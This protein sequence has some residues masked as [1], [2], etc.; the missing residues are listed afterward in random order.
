M[1]WLTV[2][3]A[4]LFILIQYPLWV[5]TGG[6][7]RVSELESQVAQHTAKNDQLKA[8]NQTLRAEVIDLKT[9]SEAIEERA[10]AELSMIKNDEIFV[11]V[12]EAPKA[13][14]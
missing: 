6:W 11:Q 8:R 14:K 13:V 1:R 4:T 10:R 2:A 9:G 12:I 3:L 7:F 5:G